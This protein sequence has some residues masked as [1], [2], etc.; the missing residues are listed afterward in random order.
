MVSEDA[1][2]G[3]SSST[4]SDQAPAERDH[5]LAEITCQLPV[6]NPSASVTFGR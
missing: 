5:T 4:K 2:M 3:D 6:P 1:L